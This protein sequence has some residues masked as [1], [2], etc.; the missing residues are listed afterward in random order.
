MNSS[1]GAGLLGSLSLF[2]GTE[3][4][5]G[6]DFHPPRQTT[7]Q[8]SLTSATLL[9]SHTTST[10]ET[11]PALC[12]GLH[13]V[14]PCVTRNHPYGEKKNGVKVFT[15]ATLKYTV[16]INIFLF[17]SISIRF[18][19]SKYYGCGKTMGRAVDGVGKSHWRFPMLYYN[20]LLITDFRRLV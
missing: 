16:R 20:G 11:P 2:L 13:N 19:M 5:L 6:R 1:P 18:I 12:K 10:H 14:C 8:F 4:E 3:V 9:N 15:S 7:V 17:F